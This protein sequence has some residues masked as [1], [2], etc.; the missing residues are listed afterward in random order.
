[1]GEGDWYQKSALG[2][3]PAIRHEL[4]AERSSLGKNFIVDKLLSE[5]EN[6]SKPKELLPTEIKNLVNVIGST[7]AGDNQYTNSAKPPDP[8]SPAFHMLSAHLM[9]LNG[10]TV[11]EVQGNFVTNT[12]AKGKEFKGIFIP[13]GENGER[14]KEFFL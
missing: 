8:R 10:K 13:S 7:T 5:N 6:L 1:M 3:V 12:G 9:P 11:L 14:I 4:L 2:N